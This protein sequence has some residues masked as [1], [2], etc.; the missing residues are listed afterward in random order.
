MISEWLQIMLEEIERKRGEQIQAIAEEQRRHLEQEQSPGN[1]REPA[2][3]SQQ[4][5]E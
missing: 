3:S 5:R 4:R 2:G 1:A